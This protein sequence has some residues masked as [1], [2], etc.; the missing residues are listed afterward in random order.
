MSDAR[1]ARRGFT[2]VEVLVATVVLA[3]GLLAA[4]TAFSLASRVASASRNDTV[5]LFLAQQKMAEVQL[6]G[7]TKLNAGTT[8]GDFG[9]EYPGYRWRLTVG[10]PDSNNV[11]S[12]DLVITAPEAGKQ[13]AA[14]FTTAL[15]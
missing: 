11:V 12:V 13:R 9:E 10:T 8:T 3:V 1:R 2:L 14:R 6:L 4:L 15:F 5:M 7:K